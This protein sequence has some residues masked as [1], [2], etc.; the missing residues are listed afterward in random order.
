MPYSGHTA[1]LV[2]HFRDTVNFKLILARLDAS[3]RQK[4]PK[5]RGFLSSGS[6][7]LPWIWLTLTVPVQ[8]LERVSEEAVIVAVMVDGS[9]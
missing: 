5:Y 8:V 6:R 3:P 7:V 1:T 4:T 9:R 2:E